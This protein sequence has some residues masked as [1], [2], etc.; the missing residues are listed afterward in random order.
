MCAISGLIAKTSAALADIEVMTTLMRH[1]GPDDE[2]YVVVSPGEV[3]CLGGADTPAEVFAAE[4]PYR[5]TGKIDADSGRGG[6]LALGHRR[7]SILDL[8]PAG[9]QPMSYAGRYWIVYNGEIY[10]YLELRAQLE[11]AGCRFVSHGD[12]EVILAAYSHWGEDCFSR[13]NGMWAIAIYDAKE[14]KLVLSRDRF[15]V[16]PLY[17]WQNESLFAFASEI[18][19]FT[20]LPGWRPRVN[21]QAVHDFLISALQDHSRETMFADVFQL[22]PGTSAT[23]RCRDWLQNGGAENKKVLTFRRWYKLL[24]RPFEGSFEDAAK[25]FREWLASAVELRL[26]S[27]VPVGSCLSGGLDSSAIVCVAKQCLSRQSGG[28]TQKTFSACSEIKRFDEREYVEQVV[29][30]TGVEPHYDYPSLGD[31]FDVLERLTWHQDEPFGSTSIFAQWCVFR[32]AARAGIKVMLDGQGADELLFGY[33]N[34]FRAYYSGLVRA[35]R[36]RAGWREMM[37][38]REKFSGALSSFVRAATDAATPMSLQRS[39]RR[40]SGPRSG[41]PGLALGR[42]NA[43]FPGPLAERFQRHRS[44]RELSMELMGG[45]HVQM[46]LHWEDRNS[47]AHSIESRVPFL[48]YRLAEFVLGLPDDF[49]IRNGLT[50]AVL[51]EGMKDIVPQAILDRRDKMGFVT[52][53]VVWVKEAGSAQ[54]RKALA[55]AIEA[56]QGLLTDQAATALDDAIAGRSDYNSTLWRMISLGVWMRKFGVSL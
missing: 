51:R 45:A 19:A 29:A 56:S 26:R 50:K 41:H 54:F 47:M 28:Y 36:W 48:D 53:E 55:D 13:F 32:L 38:R 37:A 4:T 22:E 1:R 49:K 39:Y 33:P 24:P 10:N 17:Y 9:H 20:C 35:G 2:G 42:L 16:K 31:L 18:K 23:L 11:T 7:L 5:P 6:W 3:N 12:T 21:G 44:G 34:F 52:P 25:Q 27:D 46:L 8:S 14:D 40:H 15:G 43:A 30:L